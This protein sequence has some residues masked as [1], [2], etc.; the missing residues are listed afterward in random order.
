VFRFN[1]CDYALPI[2]TM[3][4]PHLADHGTR[5]IIQRYLDIEKTLRGA[6]VPEGGM[7]SSITL[8]YRCYASAVADR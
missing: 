2:A 3:T 5:R 1:D 8:A 7:K 4:E 6:L